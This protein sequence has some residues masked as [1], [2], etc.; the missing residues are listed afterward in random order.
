MDRRE[1]IK[2]L[3]LAAAIPVSPSEALY[4]FA[5]WLTGRTDAVQIGANTDCAVVADLVRDFCAANGFSNPRDG[6]AQCL[7]YPK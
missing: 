3:P 1:T 4:G 7:T 2:T 5:A 6:W